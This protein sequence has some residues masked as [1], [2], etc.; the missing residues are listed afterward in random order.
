MTEPS[1]GLSHREQHAVLVM[2]RWARAPRWRRLRWSIPNDASWP[3]DHLAGIEVSHD[4]MPDQFELVGRR[5]WRPE[6]VLATMWR[7][8]A[9]PDVTGVP[10]EEWFRP[11]NQVAAGGEAVAHRP[12]HEAPAP[13]RESW[14]G[15]LHEPPPAPSRRRSPRLQARAAA[16][17][18]LL[19]IPAGVSGV[20]LTNGAGEG[21]EGTQRAAVAVTDSPITAAPVPPMPAGAVDWASQARARLASMDD[22]LDTLAAAE[23][24]WSSAPAA[25]RAGSPPAELERLQAAWTQLV[26]HRAELKRQLTAFE[27]LQR[28][29]ETLQ[30]AEQRLAQLRS[31]A[32]LADTGAAGQLHNEADRLAT[33]AAHARQQVDSNIRT[34]QLAAADPLPPSEPVEPVAEAVLALAAGPPDPSDP[35]PDRPGAPAVAELEPEP[36]PQPAPDVIEDVSAEETTS[37]DIGAQAQA[38]ADGKGISDVSNESSDEEKLAA[39]RA[40]GDCFGQVYG[41]AP[42]GDREAFEA[43]AEA[44]DV[45]GR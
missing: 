32:A 25:R 15:V 40:A 11:S 12:L 44:P 2:A 21:D 22:E 39:L 36:E 7:T 26:G 20:V 30:T 4:G 16:A 28:S 34:V 13:V 3:H 29:R 18:L 23:K 10:Q 37:G 14:A 1:G 38:C 31:G 6:C 42:A 17:A 8:D 19:A 9:G 35:E 24:A 27:E 45:A 33:Q 43:G 41:S 5:G